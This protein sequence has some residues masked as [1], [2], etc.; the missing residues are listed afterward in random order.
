MAE[1]AS[2]GPS[3]RGPAFFS[4]GFRPFFLGAALFAGVAVPVWILWTLHSSSEPRRVTGDAK[5]YV[6]RGSHRLQRKWLPL[7]NTSALV[8]WKLPFF[9]NAT[10]LSAH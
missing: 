1:Q 4:Y 2:E 6:H 8:V 9:M 7:G 5:K 10:Q 3:Y